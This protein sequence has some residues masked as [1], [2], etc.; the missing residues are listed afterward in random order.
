VD[1]RILG[2]LEVLDGDRALAL[3][4]VRQR[5]LLALL[6]LHA[7][8]VVSS[9]RL[10][11]T[12]WAED[13]LPSSSNALQVAVSR[14]RRTLEPSRPSGQ[15]SELLVTRAPGYVLRVTRG[16]LDLQ[17]SEDLAAAG[18]KALAAGDPARAAEILTGAL[19]LWRGPPLADLGYESFA[20]AEIGRLEELRVSVLEDRIAVDLDLGRHASVVTELRE[21]AADHPLRERVRGQLMLALYRSGR[22]ADALEAFRDARASLVGELGVEPDPTLQRLHGLILRQD[23]SLEPPKPAPRARPGSPATPFSVP[24]PRTATVGREHDITRVTELLRG[25][26][27]LTLVGAGGIGKTRLA[28]EVARATRADYPDGAG[29]VSLATTEASD[30]VA[31][32]VAAALG[33]APLGDELPLDAVV[34]LIDDK[35]MLLVFDNFE[36]VLAASPLVGALLEACEGLRI[37]ITSREPLRLSGEQV[38][39]VGPLALPARHQELDPASIQRSPAIRL[40]VE[41]CRARD[42]GFTLNEANAAPVAEICARLDGMPLAIELAAA[43]ATLLAPEQ[44]IGRLDDALTVLVG[45]P[46]D[47]PPRQQTLRATLDWSHA[48]LDEE[49]QTAFAGLAVFSGGCTL[50][51]AENVLGI[52]LSAVEALLAK[53]LVVT[54]TQNGGVPRVR[55]LE[56]VRAYAVER[57][58]ERGDAEDVRR[59]HCEYYVGLAE[60]SEPA[61]RSEDQMS[62]LHRLGADHANL[63]AAV[64]W[65]L[66]AKRAE[67]GLRLASALGNHVG[68]L[69]SEIRS[70]LETTLAAAPNV[71]PHVRAK[72]LLALGLIIGGG[73]APGEHLHEALRLFRAESDAHGA[74]QA[75]IALSI[76]TDQAGEQEL[77]TQLAEDALELART[78]GDE[79]L[80]ASALGA[81]VLGSPQ[82]FARSRHFGEQ[83]L[84]MF[85]RRGDRIQLSIALGNFGF[86]AMAAGDYA[87]AAPVLEEAVA[88]SEEVEDARVLPFATV[89]RGFLHVLQGEDRLAARD[90]TRTLALCRESGQPL[91]VGEALSGLAAIAARRG[92]MD[93]ASQLS[94]A[95]DAHRIFEAVGEPELRLRHDVIEPARACRAPSDWTREW[96]A[97]NALTFSQAIALGIDAVT[98]RSWAT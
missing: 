96:A 56:P 19:A 88:I 74:A 26:R 46:R 72:A 31:T 44:I 95:S 21:L 38:F 62:W 37:L 54:H 52:D 8:E 18:R 58:M 27:L 28:V 45:G 65:S 24:L 73:P 78:T 63:R 11:D 36:H 60:R 84:A 43:H 5:A 89:N 34:R 67:L 23:A 81:Q 33:V 35:D 77:A 68:G 69:H 22:Q 57:F 7:N 29:F 61:L 87:A 13:R 4:G 70:W 1:F 50:Q 98:V 2:P 42:V 16:Q 48:L 64:L 14:L 59:S 93:L 53:S 20:Q 71:E 82:S 40:F 12:L 25:G 85:R 41:R 90:L 15:P 6:L 91:P 83:G 55:M 75:L 17:R 76:D 92:E 94:G 86:A 51:A 9:D 79:W 97:G 39:V 49:Q 10:I 80:I 47:A 66:R 32:S 3:G 30:L